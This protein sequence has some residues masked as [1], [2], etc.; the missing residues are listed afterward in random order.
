MALGAW[1]Y[2]RG[3]RIY[4]TWQCEYRSATLALT[5]LMLAE[6]DREYLKQC[7]RCG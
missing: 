4:H 7:R 1:F 5:P 6:R 2:K 3:M